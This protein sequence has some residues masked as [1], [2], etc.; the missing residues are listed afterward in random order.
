MEIITVAD[1]QKWNGII[2]QFE[3]WDIYYLNEY[4]RSLQSH[5]DGIPYLI[6]HE[7]DGNKIAYVVMQQDISESPCFQGKIKKN[8]YFDWITP[9]GYGGPLVV[10]DITEDW[11]SGFMELLKQ[12]CKQHKIITQFFRFHP[13]LNNQEIMRSTGEV[14]S[15]KKT[16]YID[17][18]NCETIWKNMTPNNR[19]MVRKAEKNGVLIFWDRGDHLDDFLKIYEATMKDRE[20]LEYY[21]FAKEYFTYLI[22]SLPDYTVFFYALYKGEIISASIFLYN[23]RYMHYHLSGSLPEYR[24]LAAANLILTR[25]AEWAAQKK[26]PI[27]HL[28]GGLEMEDSLLSFKKH[29]NR[30][31][32]TDFFI[33]RNI[34]D[35]EQ[36]QELVR[37]R[38][39]LD[40]NF[41][42]EKKYLIL[43]RG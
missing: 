1:K 17:T 4:A 13:L 33:G 42:T 23:D 24:R 21:F 18:K 40:E 10:G 32:L 34:F 16:V 35:E 15:L 41:D 14:T 31:G 20:A 19:N 27:M 26:I 37:F 30:N 7:K 28:G 2:K 43:Y 8:S 36:Y 12:W 22:Q 5:G 25:A 38:Q 39:E 6:Y 3:S 11:M 9:Y 29:F